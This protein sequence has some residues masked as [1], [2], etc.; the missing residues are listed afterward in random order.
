LSIGEKIKAQLI[1]DCMG[2]HCHGPIIKTGENI[3]QLVI[4]KIVGVVSDDKEKK[5]NMPTWC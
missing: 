1:V 4:G 5:E 3:K 2:L